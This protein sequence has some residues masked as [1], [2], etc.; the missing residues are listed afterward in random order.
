M[1]G[2]A[3]LAAALL[4]P[5]EVHASAAA[6]YPV[7]YRILPA[8]VANATDPTGSPPGANDW[9]CKPSAAHPT[10]V[11]LA[12]GLLATMQDN[13]N[14]ISPLLANSGYCVFALTYGSQSGDPYFGGLVA[15]E[16]SAG[17][18]GAFVARVLAA[19]GAARVD[20]VGHS[21]GTV[22]P[23]YWMEFLGGARLVDRYVMLT[24]IWHGTQFYGAATLQ[25]LGAQLVPG[26]TLLEA[27]LFA[28]T[29]GSCPE[30]LTGSPFLAHLDSG[31]TALPGVTY[32]DIMTRYDELVIPY[33]S[34]NLVAPN[35]TNIVL[36][37]QCPVDYSDHL[38]VAFDP[39]AA[40]DMLNAL[41]PAHASRVPCV[42]VIAGFG[43]LYPPS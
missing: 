43:A 41:D 6:P 25:Q 20:L 27:Q 34:G 24:P 33:T 10:P 21:E 37:D 32:T 26:F 5:A 18:L 13:W 14:T 30:F 39:T 11:V 4:V 8:V 35:V 28:H 40:Q 15:M 29:C 16:Q 1:C 31:G 12:H 3:A 36:Q 7:P 38:T 9:S 23:R 19:T 22:M 2:A 17:E 42:P